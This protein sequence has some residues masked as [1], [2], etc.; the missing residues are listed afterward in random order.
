MTAILPKFPRLI[1]TIFEPLSLLAGF[2]GPFI[3]SPEKFVSEQ[4]LYS[5]TK[6][7]SRGS[8]M[9]T[10]QL[11]NVYLLLGMVGI[12]V[13][14]ST[15][16]A[17]VVKNYII[18]LWL[19]DISHVVITAWILGYDEVVD[20]PNWNAVTWGN[21]GVTSFLFLTRSAY[22]LGVFGPDRLVVAKMKIR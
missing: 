8:Q 9:V 2:L 19:A 5:T 17:K 10:Y 20:I 3:M 7:L 14:Y 12:A 6:A 18:A 1:F 22:L 4:T 21:I 11:G 13:L 16:E 15:T